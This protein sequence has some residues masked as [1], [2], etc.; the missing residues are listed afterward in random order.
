M[1]EIKAIYPDDDYLKARGDIHEA[2]YFAMLN[3][4]VSLANT[5][6]EGGDPEKALTYEKYLFSLELP[7]CPVTLKLS[8]EQRSASETAIE[9]LISIYRI[10]KKHYQDST[11]DTDNCLDA[12][13]NFIKEKSNNLG[14][15]Y[16]PSG[17]QNK[18]GGHFAGLKIRKLENGHY[19]FSV[20]NHG[21]GISYHL[22]LSTSGSKNKLSYQSDEF[23]VDLTS[24][25]GRELLQ[26]IIALRFDPQ[27]KRFPDLKTIS[28]Y[29]EHDLYGLLLAHAKKLTSPPEKIERKS[30]TPQRT[31]TCPMT[32]T[33]GVAHDTYIDND[34][35]FKDH[36]RND[37]VIKLRSLI[38]GFYAYRE[39]RYPRDIIEA[40]LREF[41]VRLNKHHDVLSEEEIIYCGQLEQQIQQYLTQKKQEI[42]QEKCKQKSLP[43]L[44]GKLPKIQDD[45][46]KEKITKKDEGNKISNANYY[47]KYPVS[48]D[49]ITLDTVI[50]LLRFTT[51][52]YF[53]VNYYYKLFTLLPPCSGQA[54]DEFWDKIP[55]N[56]LHDI[57]EYLS[58]IIARL[59]IQSFS[60]PLQR[61][62]MFAMA[63]IAYDIVAQLAPRI[64][65]F[66]LSDRY[67]LGL[68]DVYS[69]QYFIEDPICY[70]SIK[71]VAKN[72][73]Q[74][75]KNKQRILTNAVSDKT[76]P[77][78]GTV[79]Y[80]INVVLNKEQREVINQAILKKLG[81]RSAQITD[82]QRFEYIIENIDLK[83]EQ[84]EL[85]LN[86]KVANLI[87]IAATAHSLGDFTK[88]Y[89][90]KDDDSNL[91]YFSKNLFHK[92][93]ARQKHLKD[94]AIVKHLPEIKEKNPEMI[95][96]DFAENSIYYHFENLR[97][98]DDYSRRYDR[99]LHEYIYGKK[100]ELE[101]YQIHLSGS[102]RPIVEDKKIWDPHQMRPRIFEELNED[103]RHIECAP[104]LQV[105]RALAWGK[106]NLEKLKHE[107]I[108]RRI[109]EL[110]FQYG[111]L[112][113]ALANNPETTLAMIQRFLVAALQYCQ[114]KTDTDPEL[115]FWVTGLAFKL[116]YN[117]EVAAKIYQFS[118]NHLIWPNY[119][120]LL[121]TRIR[122]SQDSS[123]KAKLASQLVQSYRNKSPLSVE[124]CC[125]ILICR[126]LAKLGDE[127]GVCEDIWKDLNAELVTIVTDQN[128]IDKVTIAL[129]ELFP[130]YLRKKSAEQWQF[131]NFHLVASDSDLVLDLF[132]GCL[133]EKN[134]EDVG[135]RTEKTMAEN[136]ELFTRLHLIPDRYE[137]ILCSIVADEK[138][139]PE[140]L[141]NILEKYK[142]K[143]LLLKQG[144][145][146]YAYGQSGNSWRLTP[147]NSAI[148]TEKL[149]FPSVGEVFEAKC[150]VLTEAMYKEINS[151][152]NYIPIC[153]HHSKSWEADKN[154]IANQDGLNKNR[155]FVLKSTD[156]NW[157]FAYI[158][159]VSTFEIKSACQFLTI[160]GK[161]TRF[162]LL[163]TKEIENLISNSNNPFEA[164]KSV[165]TNYQYWQSVE[166]KDLLFVRQE[167]SDLA[168]C[169]RLQ[170]YDLVLLTVPKN[171]K[172]D[173]TNP[174]IWENTKKYNTPI[175][176]KQD[177]K[178]FIYGDSNGVMKFPNLDNKVFDN[179]LFPEE[180]QSLE[181]K[182]HDVKK[183]IYRE[184]TAK[185][186]HIPL[187]ESLIYQFKQ[188]AASEWQRNDKFLLNL[189]DPE[190]EFETQ[191]SDTLKPL[192]GVSDVRCIVAPN[193]DNHRIENIEHLTLGLSFTA[194]EK[195]QLV[196]K[197]I[198]GG[199]FISGSQSLV[200][201][202]GLP[203]V[204]TLENN[205]GNKK[206]L[207]P[208]FSLN[209]GEANNSFNLENI[210]DYNALCNK[211]Q[212]FYLYSLNHKNE[213]IADQ[214]SVEANLY[215]AILYRS[216]GDFAKA[217]KYLDNC[218]IHKNIT[219]SV[220][221]I[222]LQILKRKIQ[223]PLG[224][225]FDLKL[226]CYLK[227]HQEKWTKDKEIINFSKDWTE[228]LSKQLKFY[229]DTISN[230]RTDIAII[231]SYCRLTQSELEFLNNSP[232]GSKS[233]KE[234]N[235]KATVQSLNKLIAKASKLHESILND[236]VTAWRK[237]VEV[238]QES[239]KN[240]K[241]IYLGLTYT[242]SSL[243]IYA[244]GQN[245]AP[246]LGYIF[247]YL[248]RLFQ[249]AVSGD[250]NRLRII[251]FSLLQNDADPKPELFE[252]I[253]LLLFISKHPGYFNDF[254][255]SQDTFENIKKI[256]EIFW[257]H[258]DEIKSETHYLLEEEAVTTQLV[259][260]NALPSDFIPAPAKFIIGSIQYEQD[261][262]KPL[263]AIQQR[264]FI[265]TEIPVADKEFALDPA[266]LPKATLLEKHILNN[267][268]KGHEEN[269]KKKKADYSFNEQLTINDLTLAIK[270]LQEKD[271]QEKDQQ[272][273]P[274][275]DQLILTDLKLAL[276]AQQHQD[277]ENLAKLEASLLK[278]SNFTPLDD[279][280]ASNSDK[281]K[282][283]N[284]LLARASEQ[285]L[286]IKIDDILA[287]Y[288]HQDPNILTERNHFLTQQDISQ[289]FADL[290]DYAL[291]QSRVDQAQQ[292][293][294]I[295]ADKKS[296]NQLDSY[297]K[298]LVAEIVDKQRAYNVQDYPEFLAY[299]YITKKLLRSDQV[300]TLSK[301]I[302][303]IENNVDHEEIHH[304][305]LQ[306]A[307][308]GGK[309]SVLTPI[310]AQRFARKGFLPVIFNTNELY[311]N[312]LVDI[313]TNLRA[314][315]QQK[316]EV[317]ERDLDHVWTVE[318]LEK[319][320]KDLERWR[321]EKKCLLIKPVTW[322]SI[323][324]TKKISYAKDDTSGRK[325][326]DAAKKVLDFFKNN[327]V[328]LE[329]ES[330]IISDS[331]QQC[332]KTYGAKQKIPDDQLQLLLRFYDYLMGYEE[333]SE[334]ITKLAGIKN[335]DNKKSSITEEDL[336]VLQQ[337]LASVI[338]KEEAF[339]NIDKEQ[340][341]TY[342]LQAEKKRPQWLKDLSANI[343]KKNI[344]ELIVLSRAFL[345]THLPHI[346]SLQ[347]RKD[348]GK[349]IHPGDLTVA[350]KHEA[351]DVTSH[352]GD[353]T[354]V[355]ALTIQ[356]Y[357]QR[358][359][360]P[361]DTEILLDK[362]IDEHKKERQWN[363]DLTKPT[364][365]EQLLFSLIPDHETYAD[366]SCC[367]DLT[368]K[369][370]TLLAKDPNFYQNPQ[371]I[372]KFLVEFALPQINVPSERQI[373]TAA[374][375][376][377]G[378]KRSI[379]L[380]ATPGLPET[381][382]PFL[383][384]LFLE[385]AFEAEVVATLLEKKNQGHLIELKKFKNPTD[386]FKQISPEVL[387]DFTTL[388]DRGGLL[389]EFK[390]EEIIACY[391]KLDK[392]IAV[393][394]ATA[395]YSNGNML[396][397]SAA[398]NIENME[399][400]GSRLLE[401]VKSLK[402]PPKNLA[403]FLLLLISETTGIN[404]KRTYNDHAGLSI[405][406]GQTLLETIQAAMRERELL[407]KDGQTIRAWL[408]F[409]A[410]YKEINKI[411]NQNPDVFDLRKVFYWMVQNEARQS[412]SKLINCAYQ[413]I[414]QAV[415]DFIWEKIANEPNN[416]LASQ[417]IEKLK[418]IQTISPYD[419]YEQESEMDKTANVLDNYFKK[420][421][422][423]FELDKKDLL[424]ATI[425]RIEK[426]IKETSDLIEELPTPP[427]IQLN[428]EVQ[429]E[430][431]METETKEEHKTEQRMKTKLDQTSELVFGV[432]QYFNKQDNFQTIFNSEI[433][434]TEQR[435][436]YLQLPN[437]NAIKQPELLFNPIHFNV[438]QGA[439]NKNSEIT[440][441]KP[442]ETILVQISP[443]QKLQFLACT[444]TG[445]ETYTYLVNNIFLTEKDPCYA[446]INKNGEILHQS[447][448]ITVEKV[449]NIIKQ[450]TSQKM[451][452][453]VNFLNG[454]IS[455]PV[456]LSEIIAEQ[457]W[458]KQDYELLANGV[459]A[460]HISQ[461]PV[462][463]LGN[464]I[465]ENLCGW[466]S[467]KQRQNLT[468][469]AIK[470]CQNYKNK[471]DPQ[472]STLPIESWKPATEP[473][474]KTHFPFAYPK[475]ALEGYL[476]GV[477]PSPAAEHNDEF[478]LAALVRETKALSLTVEIDEKRLAINYINIIAE[479]ILKSS[480][481][482][483]EKIQ[484]ISK[485]SNEF[486][487]FDQMLENIYSRIIKN[488]N[489]K[490][491]KDQAINAIKTAYADFANGKSI[492]VCKAALQSKIST[493]ELS[494]EETVA[495]YIELIQNAADFNHVLSYAKPEL[496]TP[497][498]DSC[499][500]KLVKMLH[501]ANDYT[502]IANFITPEQYRALCI[503]RVKTIIDY[504]DAVN[505]SIA[506]NKTDEIYS[507]FGNHFGKMLKKIDDFKY[508]N[509]FPEH[510]IKF[511]NSSVSW[512][513]QEIEYPEI[514]LSVL[515][516]LSPELCRCLCGVFKNRFPD[517]CK[518]IDLNQLSN[519]QF[520]AV[521][522]AYKE[523]II[524]TTI[525]NQT[526]FDKI[527]KR[528]NSDQ[529][530]EI[531]K[532]IDTYVSNFEKMY[533]YFFTIRDNK[534]FQLNP[535]DFLDGKNSLEKFFLL[536]TEYQNHTKP[537]L[538]YIINM[539]N[540]DFLPYNESNVVKIVYQG[541][542][543]EKDLDLISGGKKYFKIECLNSINSEMTVNALNECI[544]GMDSNF[545]G[546]EKHLVSVAKE[547]YLQRII[548][549]MLQ[550]PMLQE[551]S[552]FF[553]PLLRDIAGQLAREIPKE[554][555][556]ADVDR[557]LNAKLL[558]MK[559]EPNEIIIL[560][561][562]VERSN[563]ASTKEETNDSTFYVTTSSFQ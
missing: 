208:A 546:C 172:I 201:L 483:E 217:I 460:V 362:I 28:D 299:E 377:A 537:K 165:N 326:G 200:A 263:A 243:R 118:I 340:L 312:G 329:D 510:S 318:E 253:A 335:N 432:E 114:E 55:K 434:Q 270:D 533:T 449:S 128:N 296:I 18:N 317:I 35:D 109:N 302:K 226:F 301:I 227:E 468:P 54:H 281:A 106:A 87:A 189:A 408:M 24:D 266:G 342:L 260:E 389:T 184:I 169:Y 52:D 413:S 277:K 430:Q 17:W 239:L 348:Y 311:A 469:I 286:V 346:L 443:D 121:L 252:M 164:G 375:F 131:E 125:L 476:F 525:N 453:Y 44:E 176:I 108:R 454:E 356:L 119:R 190:N 497:V 355:V 66:K 177:D 425:Q 76:T 400:D 145:Q 507:A 484:L 64:E 197:E 535:L 516:L 345:K 310:L 524:K 170:G 175:L 273:I 37:F 331:L 297:E 41:S 77:Y 133:R 285:K 142:K 336:K 387:R 91:W 237:H 528:L 322:H 129:K 159:E 536:K 452:T 43:N 8:H 500:E 540:M 187:P 409:K 225:A 115:L 9:N 457:K 203:N 242:F 344:A 327:S 556:V 199:Y 13:I 19:A 5:Q 65:D 120:E 206:Y 78:D 439:N 359:L 341:L 282:A 412:E 141:R 314:S 304:C 415:T 247:H 153:L 330:H 447:N 451:L 70:H 110:I 212:P 202:N 29:S 363:R 429:Q 264:Y 257:E 104:S 549:E 61:A 461:H 471:Q 138:I 124:D 338:A 372:E 448:N 136:A 232:I 402:I 14:V 529:I 291:L 272:E 410:L 349:S 213:L 513:M 167:N 527:N 354:L 378:F 49:K 221:A 501:H 259:I 224:A 499:K 521:C 3:N 258:R 93:L 154:L 148:F 438:T 149:A 462:S 33:Q 246:A 62:K 7:N 204:I 151:K 34:V 374:E 353:H 79:N 198:P 319:L 562:I 361:E 364:Q 411:N 6:Y 180:G 238:I 332:I 487:A 174:L 287:A 140:K 134:A 82:A 220:V 88:T 441:L 83:N 459:A 350:P 58:N 290:S 205:K 245:S 278:K 334:K 309:T 211:S 352:Y 481:L 234:P 328:K 474:V 490:F 229:H 370:K 321:K 4:A 445:V 423:N 531:K 360:L 57:F 480:K 235:K 381:Y 288:I 214:V 557:Y 86:P 68:D 16:L 478:E 74:R 139:K 436:Q 284:L 367:E 293:L 433:R 183:K 231:P 255:L 514:L 147:L 122:V 465:L 84:D 305:L 207:L 45:I 366:F 21:A 506:K 63:L 196:C 442:I 32:N 450:P 472:H 20:I 485:L 343:E 486:K 240:K 347:Y 51:S 161:K 426:V 541:R 30:V 92:E 130:I 250:Q 547:I 298:Q 333:N 38:D 89:Q 192:F 112:D 493:F 166:D 517:F 157:E 505:P 146:I 502:L 102:L 325:L 107:E 560:P 403:V 428:S 256:G 431:R 420:L 313:P 308:G 393:S 42:L 488:T 384:H 421:L 181:I 2:K 126:M 23:D 464:N 280:N 316:M 458:S 251:L 160:E 467:K 223:S 406:K 219:S 339:K 117:V 15:T 143:L 554:T 97:T 60:S 398:N 59:K 558:E 265:K 178:F 380:S 418:L 386:F 72:F 463:L 155:C 113:N 435:Y 179:V 194:N 26:K 241:D 56:N 27:K 391:Q 563:E 306:F 390:V 295:V 519:E 475:S 522:E 268:K 337:E 127:A 168:Y 209:K 365:A 538:D 47:K 81:Q 394:E 357:Q 230:F 477:T 320:H 504:S 455:N 144:E 532:Y 388:I 25:N 163:D 358:G 94:T 261:C 470:R 407:K 553:G 351:K 498:F 473:I 98:K 96:Q 456:I 50:E 515:K 267:L 116:R 534:F 424:Q 417:Y 218:K 550:P 440:E 437:C 262:K 294:D 523:I 307:A 186:G 156:G 396:L 383:K 385:N 491:L 518:E 279:F 137:V 80:I 369:I 544:D 561:E 283:H 182:K 559:K 216:Q 99:N 100:V 371:V 551:D 379:L 95:H 103:M 376:Q 123:L 401:I 1:K 210:V 195:N 22:P 67:V 39:G 495:V 276:K 111:R 419:I 85:V 444:D 492:N 185:N 228:W 75:A 300:E 466:D 162:K 530:N 512:L 222:A 73:E 36:K 511:F 46:V 71:R 248:E 489:T 269:Q 40:A 31:G 69:E 188:T 275:L 520:A 422:N 173:I 545:P 542:F 233:T 132:S 105:V 236:N 446:I 373:S 427:K 548:D 368:P 526:D 101:P 496:R 90:K 392:E 158:D 135:E 254:K 271:K 48:A 555:I 303:L 404:A 509:H 53:D 382:P 150:N 289:I 508:L 315:F 191:W 152:Q 399:V 494:D 416:P 324:I 405:G 539:L 503:N 11:I 323:N 249:E 215:L 552:N 292:S 244:D 193:T 274:P 543:S 12:V 171:Q 395:F 397:Q 10:L 482:T 414:D 479:S